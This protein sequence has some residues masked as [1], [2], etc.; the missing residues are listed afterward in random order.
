[1]PA[2]LPASV[3]ATD[4]GQAALM[5][6]AIGVTRG[7][8]NTLIDEGVTTSRE[9]DPTDA[10]AVEGMHLRISRARR[11]TSR[12]PRCPRRPAMCPCTSDA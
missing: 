3:R 7:V 2:A 9:A 10:T 5:D 12:W 11:G 1:M 8:V 6:A 4:A